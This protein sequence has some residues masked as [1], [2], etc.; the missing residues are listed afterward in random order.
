MASK[1][2][3]KTTPKGVANYPWLTKADT[4]F[5]AEG[6]YKVNLV[7]PLNEESQAFIDF[8][9]AEFERHVEVT[10]AT[11]GKKPKLEELGYEIDEDAG[12]VTFKIKM[13]RFGGSGANKFEK[14]IAFFDASGQPIKG[15][16]AIR[17]GSELKVSCRLFTWYVAPKCGLRMEPAAVQ[18]ITL[19]EGTGGTAAQYGFEEEEGYVAPSMSNPEGS[20]QAP[21]AGDD[22]GGNVEF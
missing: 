17:P 5:D 20:S 3:F 6:E 1:Y 10:K 7:C 8:V 9:E 19:S 13:K 11:T 14:N 15:E 4:K 22:T 21:A 12:T 2:K 16:F 18:V